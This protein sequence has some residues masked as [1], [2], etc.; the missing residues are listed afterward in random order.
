MKRPKSSALDT[1]PQ[2]RRLHL[3]NSHVVL[4]ERCCSEFNLLS[5]QNWIYK[6]CSGIKTS[7]RNCEDFISK[8][9][10][11][12]TGAADP[13]PNCMTINRN[14]F[15][16]VSEFCYLGN[17]IGQAVSC[18]DTVTACNGSVWKGFYELL[19]TL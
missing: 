17:V 10:S 12:T 9:C 2:N 4:Y 11:T 5:C 3:S 16:I 7:L 15:D 6:Q 14:E 19:P 13:F 1:M 18:I 8:T